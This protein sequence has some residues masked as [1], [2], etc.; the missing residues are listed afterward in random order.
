MWNLPIELLAPLRPKDRTRTPSLSST[1]TPSG[2]SRATSIGF[3]CA[4]PLRLRGRNRRVPPPRGSSSPAPLGR[5]FV[6]LWPFDF[7]PYEVFP[8]AEGRRLRIR[9]WVR[10]PFFFV[11]FFVVDLGYLRGYVFRGRRMCRPVC[12][13][14]RLCP[15]VF[16]YVFFSVYVYRRD[17]FHRCGRTCFPAVLTYLLEDLHSKVTRFI[18]YVAVDPNWCLTSFK[19]ASHG[20]PNRCRKQ[21]RRR[22]ETRLK[23]T[24]PRQLQVVLC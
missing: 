22:V 2:A 10:F 8:Q 20:L 7:L 3:S 4:P 24:D 19:K 9:F 11:Y 16:L 13:R 6:R 21:P 14:L 15:S 1:T 17:F 18:A 23:M 5:P 12:V